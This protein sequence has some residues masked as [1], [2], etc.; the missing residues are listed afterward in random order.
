[1]A[2]LE[3]CHGAHDPVQHSLQLT[4]NCYSHG[5]GILYNVTVSKAPEDER[6]HVQSVFR[7]DH[8]LE[9]VTSDLSCPER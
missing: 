7:K 1:M 2:E 3:Q 8:Y 6:F 4:V 5:R 9:K